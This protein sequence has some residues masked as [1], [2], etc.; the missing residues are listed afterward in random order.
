LTNW[1]DEKGDVLTT[2][3]MSAKLNGMNLLLN[4]FFWLVSFIYY[5]NK[6]NYGL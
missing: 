6:F 1:S 4:L 5:V 2:N 3:I